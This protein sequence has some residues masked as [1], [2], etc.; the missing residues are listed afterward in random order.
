MA[1]V[2]VTRVACLTH[3]ADTDAILSVIHRP[4]VAAL[5]QGPQTVPG[6]R[7]DRIVSLSLH[8]HTD[9]RLG[10]DV[11]ISAAELVVGA[12]GLL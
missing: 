12:G 2:T 4:D 8:R 7:D 3:V 10:D 11:I 1:A 5:S 9:E 6:P